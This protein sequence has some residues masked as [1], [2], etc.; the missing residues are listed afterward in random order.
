MRSMQNLI[1]KSVTVMKNTARLGVRAAKCE[2]VVI[3]FDSDD[4]H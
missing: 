4:L 3:F 2:L 1:K